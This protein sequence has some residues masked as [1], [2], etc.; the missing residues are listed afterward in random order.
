MTQQSP[1]V[2]S[3][4][5]GRTSV[6][7]VGASGVLGTEL[8]SLLEEE[9]VSI[10]ELR[11][12]ASSGSA[13]EVYRVR[14]EEVEIEEFQPELL[15]GVDV[16]VM[17]TPAGVARE[18]IPAIARAGVACI[19]DLTAAYRLDEGVELIAPVIGI[20]GEYRPG[21]HLSV[22][23]ASAAQVAA[24]VRAASR[25][26]KVTEVVATT[27]QSV[28]DAGRD[29]L[30]ELWGQSIAIFNQRANEGEVFGEQIAFN[31]IPL[32]GTVHADGTSSEELTIAGEVRRLV[33]DA[34]MTVIATAIRVPVFHGSGV[35]ASVRCAEGI[36]AEDLCV[37][38]QDDPAITSYEQGEFPMQLSVVGQEGVHVGRLRCLEATKRWFSV[39]TAVDN[40][41]GVGARGAFAVI[42]DY[43]RNKKGRV[44]PQ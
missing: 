28:S 9:R 1:T 31:C 32:I 25:Q 38:L 36:S 10:D 2:E 19:V 27:L 43:V 44:M 34:A 35:S 23:S 17:A 3:S 21:K 40:V 37:A 33:G 5:A 20:G 39:W 8:L 14:G 18:V 11:L 29:G 26:A 15:A 16:V 4:A 24:V 7:I 12:F 6:A 41:R 13:G 30:D 42:Q 22:A